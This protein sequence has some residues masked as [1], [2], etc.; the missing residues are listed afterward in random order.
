[1]QYF[2][3]NYG[4]GRAKFLAICKKNALTIDTHIH[5]DV[6]SPQGHDLAMD[7]VWVGP[8]Q[9]AKV[10]LISCGTHGLEAGPGSATILQ[11]LDGDALQSIPKDTA[12][13]IVHAVNPYG[14]AYSSRTNEGNIDKRNIP[15]ELYLNDDRVGQVVTA[16]KPLKAKEFVLIPGSHPI[17]T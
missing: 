9:A 8:K 12:I 3:E 4:D 7:C 2:S 10:L 6:R 15:I 17:K 5:P 16:F 11:W 1:M 14:W 13:L